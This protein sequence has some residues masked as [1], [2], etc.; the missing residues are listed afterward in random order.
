MCGLPVLQLKT[1]HD[2]AGLDEMDPEPESKDA[3]PGASP[4]ASMQQELDDVKAEVG[5]THRPNRFYAD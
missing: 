4:G 2:L 5:A 1:A 3:A